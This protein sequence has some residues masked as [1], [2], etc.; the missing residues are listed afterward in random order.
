MRALSLSLALALVVV[1]A[2]LGCSREA[3]NAVAPTLSAASSV[4]EFRV[5]WKWIDATHIEK[6]YYVTREVHG[7]RVDIGPL[8]VIYVC[9]YPIGFYGPLPPGHC[10]TD[11][12][13]CN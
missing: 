9:D 13:G 5:T 6:T 12:S 7:Q 4:K 10:Y 3:K 1:V 2:V 11:G 8:K